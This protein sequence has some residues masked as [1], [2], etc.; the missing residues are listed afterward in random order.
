[1]IYPS[2]CCRKVE[3][4]SYF[5][6]LHCWCVTLTAVSCVSLMCAHQSWR[7]LSLGHK[8]RKADS[9][10]NSYPTSSWLMTRS[11][12]QPSMSCGAER[13]LKGFSKWL[14]H[15]RGWRSTEQGFSDETGWTYSRGMLSAQQTLSSTSRLSSIVR[16]GATYWQ[17]HRFPD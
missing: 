4:T 7:Q 3:W 16:A 17:G 2:H 9:E 15:A 12:V 13:T 5:T 8:W 1:M 10:L 11:C 14:S 6:V